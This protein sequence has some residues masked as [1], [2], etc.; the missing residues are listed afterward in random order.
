MNRIIVKQTQSLCV[1]G[2]RLNNGAKMWSIDNA[3]EKW[4][5]DCSGKISGDLKFHSL[6][7]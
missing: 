4:F 2:K 5:W 7:D 6:F 1:F 3:A